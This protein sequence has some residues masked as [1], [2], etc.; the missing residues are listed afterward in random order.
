MRRSRIT[1]RAESIN[2]QID[3]A[4]VLQEAVLKMGKPHCGAVEALKLW[5]DGKS[6]GPEGRH[7]PTFS[8]LC[9]A[10]LNNEEDLVA[11]HPEFDKDWLAKLVELPYLRLL[12]LVC[13]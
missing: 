6:E 12:C 2:V 3:E 4:L 1:N 7:A 5:L 10:R 11:L 9:A 8:G 13:L